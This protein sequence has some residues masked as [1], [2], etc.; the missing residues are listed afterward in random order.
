MS[1][2][3]QKQ[4]ALYGGPQWLE[5][6]VGAHRK[7]SECLPRMVQASLQGLG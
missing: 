7:K 3:E 2:H 6:V 1:Y 4:C 5:N